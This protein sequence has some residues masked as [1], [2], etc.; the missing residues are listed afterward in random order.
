MRL[1]IAAILLASV[2]YVL[3]THWLMTRAQPSPWNVVGVLFPMLAAIAIGAWRGGQRALAAIAALGIAALCAPAVLGL[4][5]APPLLYLAQHAGIH[6]F[7]AVAFG[8]TLRAGHTPLI[9]TLAARVHRRL[10]PDMVAYTRK[11]TLAWVLYFVAMA[12]ISLGL[13]ALAPFEAWALFANLLTPCAMVAMF[14]VEYLLRY[15]WH[16]EFERASIADAIRSYRHDS[17]A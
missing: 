8:S 3:G 12:L 4:P 2:A 10:T 11:L 13:F 9:T 7:L 5:V 6:L 14:V 16:P 1:R 15:H 17:A